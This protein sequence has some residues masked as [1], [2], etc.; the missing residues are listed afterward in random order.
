MVASLNSEVKKLIRSEHKTR[1][2]ASLTKR[3][4]V[5]ATICDHLFYI[6]ARKQGKNIRFKYNTDTEKLSFQDKEYSVR[7]DD[8]PIEVERLSENPIKTKGGGVWQYYKD[9]N[10]SVYHDFVSGLILGLTSDDFYVYAA[11]LEEENSRY[12][13]LKSLYKTKEILESVENNWFKNSERERIIRLLRENNIDY[14]ESDG[15]FCFNRVSYTYNP[16]T[17]IICEF[18]GLQI[19]H[20]YGMPLK[21]FLLQ[22]MLRPWK[23]SYKNRLEKYVSSL[24]Q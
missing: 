18:D 2:G 15:D 8:V 9:K 10:R 1:L 17:K 24:C 7:L 23:Q 13:F 16:K 20:K 12:T 22:R 3:G 21:E 5:W 19:T 11:V 4:F 14:M 6:N